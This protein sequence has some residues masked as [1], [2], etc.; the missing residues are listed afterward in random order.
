MLP[1]SR[2]GDWEEAKNLKKLLGQENSGKM[3]E[4]QNAGMKSNQMRGS[5]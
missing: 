2:G 4:I 1:V 5:S 3:M